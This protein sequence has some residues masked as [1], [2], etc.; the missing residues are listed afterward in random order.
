ML[1]GI[2]SGASIG[3]LTGRLSSAPLTGTARPF[4][5]PVQSDGRG[6]PHSFAARLGG[7]ERTGGTAPCGTPG[8]LLTGVSLVAGGKEDCAGFLAGVPALPVAELVADGA[9]VGVGSR[10]GSPGTNDPRAH[11]SIYLYICGSQRI[12]SYPLHPETLSA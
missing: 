8:G 5:S 7:G 11:I 9:T 3:A 6:W 1:N 10:C 4:G 12:L 2:P